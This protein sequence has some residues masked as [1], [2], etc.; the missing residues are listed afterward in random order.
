[1]HGE[2]RDPAPSVSAAAEVDAGLGLTCWFSAGICSLV[3]GR[4]LGAAVG[5]SA[6][7]RPVHRSAAQVVEWHGIWL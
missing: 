1:M 4:P 7:A 6:P 5:V 3:P 2:L